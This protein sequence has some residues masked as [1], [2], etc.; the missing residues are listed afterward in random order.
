MDNTSALAYLSNEGGTRSLAL[1]SEAQVILE[2]L[3]DHDVLVLPQFVQ[4]R[5]NVVADALSRPN[6]VI[7]TE[8][9]LTQ[10]VVDSLLTAWPA[11]IDL[12]A[13]SLNYR[14]P[15]FFSPFRDPLAAGTDA[16]L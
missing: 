16:F 3:E 12:F 9:T 10:E 4:G 6:M 2:W 8:W 1:N 7:S 11:T 5:D 15:V 13:T 14:F